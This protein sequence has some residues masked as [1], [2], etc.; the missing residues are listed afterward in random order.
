MYTA[1]TNFNY[2]ITSLIYC[3]IF[4]ITG[5]TDQTIFLFDIQPQCTLKELESDRWLPCE[6]AIC[7]YSL[8]EG[9][10]HNYHCFIHP[11]P[12]P[13]GY[14]LGDIFIPIISYFH[15]GTGIWLRARVIRHICYQLMASLVNQGKTI[16][17]Y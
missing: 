8:T 2:A 5:A 7:V 16:V 3:F 10:K 12:I 6:L 9:T 17:M 14:R 1:E 4:S 15:S 13:I 11:G